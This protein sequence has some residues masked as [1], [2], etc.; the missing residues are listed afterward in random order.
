VSNFLA[1]GFLIGLRHALDPDHVAAV[2]SL[3]TRGGTLRDHARNGALWGV[4]HGLTLLVLAGACVVFGIV[5]P[6]SLGRLLEA[7]VGLMLVW[8]GASVFVRMRR[9][10]IHVHGHVHAD[11]TAHVHAHG[12]AHGHAASASGEGVHEHPHPRSS[13]R[14]LVVGAVHGLAG[15][16]ALVLLV[17]STAQSPTLG[18][19]YIALFGA[20][21]VVGMMLLAATISLPLRFSARRVARVHRFLCGGVGAFSI[22]LGAHLIWEL[23]AAR[24]S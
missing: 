5:I 3:S 1:L 8:L 14:T 18:L 22:A 23:A 16:S 15:S 21:A 6:E 11:G 9:L 4:G 19:A 17:G 20:G 7:A 13:P 24:A 10:G 12:H 2:V